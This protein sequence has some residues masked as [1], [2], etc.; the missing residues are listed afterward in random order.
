M[1]FMESNVFGSQ[2]T[3][4]LYSDSAILQKSVMW[5]E[6]ALFL[7]TMRKKCKGSVRN[8][9]KRG[10]RNPG[11]THFTFYVRAKLKP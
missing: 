11:V 7:P 8:L 5:M 6:N 2:V 10:R 4:G 9:K 3:E 1:G